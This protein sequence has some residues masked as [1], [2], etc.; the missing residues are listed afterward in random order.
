MGSYI[1]EGC[2]E[3]TEEEDEFDGYKDEEPNPCDRKDVTASNGLIR[4]AEAQIEEAWP[5]DEFS[6]PMYEVRGVMICK[7]MD[8]P[9]Q[10]ENLFHS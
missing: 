6:E 2:E 9:S 10:R 4:K 7:A 5:Q 1:L 3:E 8:D